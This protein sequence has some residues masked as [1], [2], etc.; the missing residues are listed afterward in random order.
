MSESAPAELPDVPEPIE[1]NVHPALQA[2]FKRL[3]SDYLYHSVEG[4]GDTGLI[5]CGRNVESD[6]WVEIYSGP[7]EA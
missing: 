3:Y 2:A 6:P 7:V 1:I 5:L 4:V